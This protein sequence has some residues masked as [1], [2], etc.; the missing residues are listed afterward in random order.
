MDVSLLSNLS[1]F[2]CFLG[3]GRL[4][5][6][7]DNEFVR[8]YFWMSH[9][10]GCVTFMK[11]LYRW[12]FSLCF[13]NTIPGACGGQM[14]GIGGSF[15]GWPEALGQ[16]RVAVAV[17]PWAA[18]GSPMADFAVA[19]AQHAKPLRGMSPP[20]GGHRDE[21]GMSP[22][23]GCQPLGAAGRRV[24]LELS[25]RPP[26]GD[27]SGGSNRPALWADRRIRSR[28]RSLAKNSIMF[29]PRC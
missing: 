18:R 24:I 11:I 1:H 10:A 27:G 21:R 8:L 19:R 23:D 22:P 4:S 26:D 16:K 5:Y 12:P 7:V 6:V 17:G 29:L 25:S 9:R 3:S 20:D 14:P 2:F 15:A 13:V 28:N